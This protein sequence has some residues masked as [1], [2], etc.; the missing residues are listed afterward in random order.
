MPQPHSNG[1]HYLIIPVK[2]KNAKRWR[3]MWLYRSMMPGS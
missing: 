1:V 2:S 3:M